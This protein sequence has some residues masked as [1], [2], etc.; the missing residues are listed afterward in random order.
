MLIFFSSKVHI[1]FKNLSNPQDFGLEETYSFRLN[2]DILGAWHV[3]PMS[4]KIIPSN[5]VDDHFK[6]N[7]ENNAIVVLYLHGNTNDRATGYRVGLYN[8]L[9]S[10]GYHVVTF[11][12]RGYGDSYGDPSELNVVEV[13]SVNE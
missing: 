11:D 7:V 1:P 9:A 8:L 5:N 10:H 4:S 13:S 3:M 6:T 2:N 12:Y